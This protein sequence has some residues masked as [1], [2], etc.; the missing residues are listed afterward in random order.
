MEH[1]DYYPRI[2]N[3]AGSEPVLGGGVGPVRGWPMG[4]GDCVGAKVAGEMG[5]GYTLRAIGRPNEQVN[6]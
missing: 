4:E 3:P 5:L 1:G 6:V 2:A